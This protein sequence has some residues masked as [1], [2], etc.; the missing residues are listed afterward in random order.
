MCVQNLTD[1]NHILKI[2]KKSNKR[3]ND[4]TIRSKKSLK[5]KNEIVSIYLMSNG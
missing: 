5:I 3:E 1:R 4:Y 2:S